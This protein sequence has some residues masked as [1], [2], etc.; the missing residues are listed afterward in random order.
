VKKPVMVVQ[1]SAPGP[2]VRTSFD[3]LFPPERIAE[4]RAK[5]A[6][7]LQAFYGKPAAELTDRQVVRHACYALRAQL[8]QSQHEEPK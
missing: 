8:D 5:A 7:S 3:E 1:P 4:Y 2:R 6:S